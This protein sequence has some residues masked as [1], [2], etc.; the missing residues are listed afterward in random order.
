[1]VFGLFKYV[2]TM[3]DAASKLK[4]EGIDDIR[5]FSPVPVDHEMDPVLGEKKNPLRFFTFFGGLSGLFFGALLVLTTA[6][7]YVLPRGG[8]PIWAA[9]PVLLVSYET[10][11]LFGVLMTYFGFLVLSGLIKNFYSTEEK[12]CFPETMDDSFGLLINVRSDREEAVMKILKEFG[13]SEV[14]TIAWE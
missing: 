5:V 14:R 6:A 12:I 3:A 2:D 11:I 8:K 4:T 9:P 7:L 13:A 10:T 1:M